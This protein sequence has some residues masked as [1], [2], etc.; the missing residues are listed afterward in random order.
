MSTAAWQFLGVL[1]TVLVTFGVA[2]GGWI[3]LR[4]G[5]K[6]SPYE[7]LVNRVTGLEER[8]EKVEAENTNLKRQSSDDQTEIISLKR[9]MAGV[10][11]DRDD[12]VA[13]VRVMQAWIANG[14]RPP[15]PTLPRHLADSLPKWVP[16]DGAEPPR[17]HPPHKENSA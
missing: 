9:Q 8:L 2:I 11:S 12:L 5:R 1:A 10:I 6:A 17:P 14:S 7:A 4:S 16:G 13:Y 3:S 15:A